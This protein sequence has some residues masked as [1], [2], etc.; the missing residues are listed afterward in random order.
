[1][2]AP[3]SEQGVVNFVPV[4]ALAKVVDAIKYVAEELLVVRLHDVDRDLVLTDPGT[5]L[6]Q[7]RPQRGIST[8][9]PVVDP[10][11]EDRRIEHLGD[12]HPGRGDVTAPVRCVK[13]LRRGVEV[14]DPGI[15]GS[16]GDR[17]RARQPRAQSR[18]ALLSVDDP[19][20][21]VRLGT[22]DVQRSHL[23]ARSGRGSLAEEER[24]D[25]V[26]PVDT[27][28]EGHDVFRAPP[29][30]PLEIGHSDEPAAHAV[31]EILDR[32][33]VGFELQILTRRIG[34]HPRKLSTPPRRLR[35]RF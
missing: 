6:E 31:D 21:L 10:L 24:T 32:L 14:D 5:R 8:V 33:G 29:Q 2:L 34:T 35:A 26:S 19:Q 4:E 27:V 15:V 3:V 9:L 18:E 7:R 25:G 30:A 13:G 16:P 28:E 17:S 1:M 22:V 12:R 11:A 20:G 23:Q